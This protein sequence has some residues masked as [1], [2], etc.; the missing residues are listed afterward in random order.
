MRRLTI[1][2][3]TLL[4]FPASAAAVFPGENGPIVFTIGNTIARVQSDGSGLQ[5]VTDVDDDDI[6][7]RS[8]TASADGSRLAFQFSSDSAG[9]LPKLGT[10]ALDD[11]PGFAPLVPTTLS[12][13]EPAFLANDRVVYR[14]YNGTSDQLFTAD[15]D[16]TGATQESSFAKEDQAPTDP[17]VA[18]DGD[19]VYYATRR[20]YQEVFEGVSLTVSDYAIWW[21]RLSDGASGAVTAW[22][23]NQ[24]IRPLD[25]SPDG[26]KLLYEVGKDDDETMVERT[27][28]GGAE[29]TARSSPVTSASYSPDGEFI[30]YALEDADD[31]IFDVRVMDAPTLQND[32]S[33]PFPPDEFINTNASNVEWALPSGLTVTQTGD[34]ADTDTGDGVCDGDA[35][36][37]TQCTLRAAIETANAEDGEDTIGFDVGDGGAQTITVAAELPAVTETVKVDGT[38]QPGFDGEPLVSVT[39]G[40]F[41]G[42]ALEGDDS[43]VKGLDIHGFGGAG[44]D[45]RAAGVHV[46]DN[47]LAGNGTP[48]A[49]GKAYVKGLDGGEGPAALHDGLVALGAG[50][51]VSDTDASDVVIE[52]NT[53][54]GETASTVGVAI[55]P[56]G[57][58]E[59]ATV[60]DNDF[61]GNLLGVV[62]LAPVDNALDDVQIRENRFS[63]F[64]LFGVAT[65]GQVSN[66]VIDKNIIKNQI[67]GIMAGAGAAPRITGN[68][69]GEDEDIEALMAALGDED[70]PALGGHNLFGILIGGN[71]AVVGGSGAAA[72]TIVGNLINVFLAGDGN[73]LLGN[74]IGLSSF[75]GRPETV[76]DLGSVIGVLLA[77]TDSDI[78]D[79]G[80]GNAFTANGIASIL[81]GT[82]RGH[83]RANEVKASAIGMIGVQTTDLRIDE[84]NAFTDNLM[85]A[86]L[87]NWAPTPAELDK[88]G[89]DAQQVRIREQDRRLAFTAESSQGPL[90]LADAATPADVEETAVA[91]GDPPGGATAAR[92]RAARRRASSGTVIKGNRFETNAIGP[93]LIGSHSS[94]LVEDN[95]IAHND[96]GGLWLGFP[97][98]FGSS[99]A[100]AEGVVLRNNRIFDNYRVGFNIPAVAA[101]GFDLLEPKP[102]EVSTQAFGVTANDP[103]DADTGPNGLQNTPT[104]DAVTPTAVA[105]SLGSKP[106]TKYTIELFANTRCNA[107]GSGEGEIPLKTFDVTTDGAGNATFLQDVAVPDGKGV[108]T[109]NATGPEGTSEF[110]PCA[111]AAPATPTA[112]PGPGPAPSASPTAT[113]PKDTT[114]PGGTAKGGKAPKPGDPVTVTV[115]SDE[116]G[117]VSATGAITTS[118]G[119]KASI[120]KKKKHRK[121]VKVALRR[122]RTP[123]KAG[124]KKKLKLKPKGKKAIR[125]LK[126]AVRKGARATAT[127]KVTFTDL[128]GNRSRRTVKV[129]LRKR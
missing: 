86:L 12:V 60:R 108:V 85:P 90:A 64:G 87:L 67:I 22:V 121:R 23:R 123:I 99:V 109:A 6:A 125:R 83:F 24:A 80:A 77:G 40:D 95:Q 5:P 68:T 74:T 107:R 50:V 126:K 91:L 21:F 16:G 53:F 70:E 3:L 102:V 25:V 111:N 122:A 10:M 48:P 1:A 8:V 9:D 100:Q 119:A 112:T 75:D 28:A 105:G 41:S 29:R 59:G 42:L 52:G 81:V 110:S 78:G 43:I 45:V 13:T 124:Q 117:T 84:G 128:A 57:I 63:D 46:Q 115:T 31:A 44:I 33:V 61:E 116:D 88:A 39:G 118:G 94:T 104:L 27:L 56:D 98:S 36:D 34:G 73:A 89:V 92:G 19:T 71:G 103:G 79:A 51:V 38:T 114:K 120:A 26:A 49:E 69:I 32:H 7:H 18:P 72:N 4:A 101:L 2:L 65:V 106:S 97:T 37:G 82:T 66:V 127:I 58:L 35:A 14:K 17:V 47:V 76:G 20:Y 15:A 62:A 11:T 113:P 129:E 93:W 96:G 55:A 30:A 54:G